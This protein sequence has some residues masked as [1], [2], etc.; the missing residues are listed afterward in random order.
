MATDTRNSAN[1]LAL[2]VV[3]GVA[4]G[5]AAMWAMERVV[6]YMWEHEDPAARKKYEEVTEGKYVPDRAAEQVERA[7]GLQLT[8]DQEQQLAMG[9]H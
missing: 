1:H 8:K 7:A 9:L 6:S 2:D 3:K 5:A 4:A